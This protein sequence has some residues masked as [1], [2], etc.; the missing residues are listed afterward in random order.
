MNQETLKE[1]LTEAMRKKS[2]IRG[3]KSLATRGTTLIRYTIQSLSLLTVKD[4]KQFQNWDESQDTFTGKLTE[5]ENLVVAA[6]DL[7]GPIPWIRQKPKWGKKEEE[8]TTKD[9][10]L[11]PTESAKAVIQNPY[12]KAKQKSTTPASKTKRYRL[13]G[14]LRTPVHEGW[15]PKDFHDKNKVIS[16]MFEQ[17][18]GVMRNTD[19]EVIIQPFITEMTL[20]KLSAPAKPID[21]RTKS[22]PRNSWAVGDYIDD[23]FHASGQPSMVQ[24]CISTTLKPEDFVAEFNK[25]GCQPRGQCA[26]VD[27]RGASSECKP[28]IYCSHNSHSLFSYSVDLVLELAMGICV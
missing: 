13:N 1:F 10:T 12:A 25:L 26:S 16:G 11:T 6:I 9:S 14:E 4:M 28:L 8:K 23:T 18:T 17:L 15:E 5:M 19:G 7:L 3:P 20:G 24:C 2:R 22:F 27:D 21:E